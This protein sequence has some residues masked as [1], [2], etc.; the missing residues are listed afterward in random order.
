MK[1]KKFFLHF[2]SF[3]KIVKKNWTYGSITIGFVGDNA[4]VSLLYILSA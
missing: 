4:L 2:F 1:A 3:F